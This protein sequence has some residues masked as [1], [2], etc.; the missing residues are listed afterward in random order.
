ML[1]PEWIDYNGHLRDAYYGL[2]LSYAADALMD[3]IGMDAAYR[4]ATHNTLY[5]V[6]MH[7]HFLREVHAA[8][9]VLV[10]AHILGVDRK[11]LH[12]GFALHCEGRDGPA[13]TAEFMLLHV[14]QGAAVST[15][16][17]EPEVAT[18]IERMRP[19]AG[20]APWSGPGSRRLELRGR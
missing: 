13:A 17:F 2:I 6:E 7:V 18:A 8:E 9:Q 3:R 4:A 1:A 11:R 5:T 16:A 19:Q 12:V 10:N 20:A 14:H 15:C